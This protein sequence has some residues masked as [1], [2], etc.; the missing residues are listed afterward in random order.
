MFGLLSWT[1]YLI[2]HFVVKRQYLYFSGIKPNKPQVTPNAKMKP[3]Y[4]KRLILPQI[5]RPPCIWDEVTETQFSHA[6]LEEKFALKPPAEKPQTAT[7][8]ASDKP[9]SVLDVKRSNA[10]AFMIAK[11]PAFPVLKSGNV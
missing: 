8:V 6:N 1:C 11:L 10:I 2:A 5:T 9:V 4:W 7:P 3:L